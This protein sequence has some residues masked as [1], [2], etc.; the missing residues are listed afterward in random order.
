MITFAHPYAA[1]TLSVILRDPEYGDSTLVNVRTQV[2]QSMSGEIHSFRRTSATRDL[3]LTFSEISK[4]KVQELIDFLTTAA[5]DEIKYTDYEAVVW[6]GWLITNPAE[7]ITNS[8]K[9]GTCIEVSTITLE[10][11]GSK[12]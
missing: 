4:P 3:L 11:R 7:F 10:F 6:R 1:P 8:K 9:D 2:R 12:V 5:G